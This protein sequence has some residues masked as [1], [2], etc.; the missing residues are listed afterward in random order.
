MAKLERIK[1]ITDLFVEGTEV[2]LGEDEAGTPVV[3]WVNK[4]NSF[5]LEESR[6]DGL[7]ARAEKIM[8]LKDPQSPERKI[9]EVQ[10]DSLS[11]DDMITA[12]ANRKYDED[13][14]HAMNDV[15]SDPEW[16]DRLLFLQRM[17]ELHDDAGIKDDDERRKRHADLQ[18]NYFNA[19]REAANKRQEDR[20]QELADLDDD[21]LRE[22]F[23][24]WTVEQTSMTS[25]MAEMRVTQLFYAVRDCQ[26]IPDEEGR[27]SKDSHKGCTHERML[28]E[29]HEVNTLPE[30]VLSAVADAL[31]RVTVDQRTSGNSAAPTSSSESSEPASTPEESTPSIPVV[32]PPVAVAT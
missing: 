8:E 4:V 32:T 3:V 5:E 27:F 2:K 6:R 12:T 28:S 19:L 21:E 20:K 23:I 9:L 24:E 25:Y 26:A 16:R 14:L 18:T 10:A 11:R 29:R 17:D 22:R 31:N 7:A 30:E 1:R 13:Y 15:E